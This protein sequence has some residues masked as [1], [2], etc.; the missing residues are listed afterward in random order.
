MLF[1]IFL[2][3]VS[4]STLFF[5]YQTYLVSFEKRQ[6]LQSKKIELGYLEKAALRLNAKQMEIHPFIKNHIESINLLSDLKHR[7]DQEINASWPISFNPSKNMLKHEFSLIKS[8]PMTHMKIKLLQKAFMDE[9]DLKQLFCLVEHKN[10][11][12]YT[13][14]TH[15]PY[16][17]FSHFDLKK[18]SIKA[19]EKVYEVNYVLEAFHP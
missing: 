6:L 3:V 10:I 1:Q 9:E 14:I 16:L 11:F 17:F 18:H 12:P 15:T 7:H 4:F 8:R 5:S 2:L 13:T 19:F